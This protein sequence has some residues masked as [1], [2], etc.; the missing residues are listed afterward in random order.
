MIFKHSHRRT[1]KSLQ[2]LFTTGLSDAKRRRLLAEVEVC[3]QCRVVCRRYHRYEAALAHAGEA[4]STFAVER[5]AEGIFA[6]L[7]DESPKKSRRRVGAKALVIFTP[8]VALALLILFIMPKSASFRGS[9]PADFG[10]Y[11]AELVPR[12][13][14][15]SVS[16]DFGFR[17]FA[18]SREKGRIAENN[19][20][21]AGGLLTFTY[22]RTHPA[23]GYLAL[24]GVQA[25]SNVIW[26]Y[27]DFDEKE[28]IQIGGNRVDEPLGDGFKV[29]VHHT[30]GPLLLA[31]LFSEEPIS[32]KKIEAVVAEQQNTAL[33]LDEWGRE[34]WVKLGENVTAYS[35]LSTVEDNNE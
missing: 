27:P 6:R 32:T 5:M 22:T 18:V 7:E 34:V 12:G 14:P 15:A 20:I 1:E 11:S 33:P 31:A 23:P 4:D 26:Y 3:E 29:S 13:G 35:I 28:S 9:L 21:S 10:A 2:Q 17:A 25:S 19:E 24:F 8:M 16:P 30:K